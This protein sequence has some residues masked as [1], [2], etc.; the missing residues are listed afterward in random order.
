LLTT[1]SVYGYLTDGRTWSFLANLAFFNQ[2]DALPGVFGGEPANGPL[3]TL[4]HEA[5]C[6]A[7]VAILGAARLL[8]AKICA[9][10]CLLLAYLATCPELLEGSAAAG[11]LFQFSM[12][13]P[14]FF[15]GAAAALLRD[16][17]RLEARHAALAFATLIFCAWLGA[18]RQAMPI[19][20]GYLI[21]YAAYARLGPLRQAGGFGDFSYGLYLWGWPV[22]QVA[23]AFGATTPLA[24]VAVAFPV[25]VLLAIASWRLVEAPAL[26]LKTRLLD[27]ARPSRTIKEQSLAL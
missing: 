23:L 8:N 1:Y 5:F 6:Y 27:A 24:N 19:A 10:L 11:K 13:A 9:S 4:Q 17:L 26:H 14:C 15:A 22:Q 2:A 18:F 12:L 25:T 20:G 16:H 3:W 21:L 7:L